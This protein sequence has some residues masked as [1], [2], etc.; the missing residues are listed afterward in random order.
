M[1]LR[2][3]IFGIQN[4]RCMMNYALL[5]LPFLT[6]FYLL[7]HTA[8]AQQ[9]EF[10][11]LLNDSYGDGWNGGVLT[12]TNGPTVLQLILSDG[13]DSIVSFSATSG[14][15]VQLNWTPGNIDFE[16]SISLLNNDGDLLFSVTDP[17]AGSL[18][19]IPA[20][21]IACLKPLNVV[22]E[23]VYD[24][25]AKVRWAPAVGT[26]LPVGWWVIYD[27]TGFTPGP[28]KGDSLYVMLPKATIPGLAKKTFYDFYVQQDC[29]NGETGD[30]TGPFTFETYRSDDVGITGAPSP[31]SGCDL[32]VE[33]V[34]IRMTNFGANPQS[35]I[36]FNYSVNG[37][38]AGVPQPQD[39][40][41]TGVIGKDSTTIIEFETQ[42]DF[43]DPGE[44]LIEVWTEMN[45]DE[46]TANDTFR[47]RI[48]NRLEAPYEQDFETWSGGWHVDTSAS[49]FS[50]WEFGTPNTPGIP[51]AASGKNAWVTNLDGPYSPGELSYL[52]SP[53]FD[54][55]NLANDPVIEFSLIYETETE[56]DGGFLEMSDDDG[57]NW[58]KIGAIEE[59][60]NWYNFDNVNTDLGLVWAG[61]SNGWVIA[62]HRLPGAAGKASVR[63][64]FGFGSDPLF[65]FDGMGVD[66]IRV[67]EPVADDLAGLTISTNADGEDCGLVDDEV[68][69]RFINLG[70]Q[71]QTL[72]SVSYALNGTA[73]VTENV[74]PV[75]VNPDEIFEYTFTT[76]FNSQ[77]GLFE[78]K[79]WTNLAGDG[80]PA[81]DTA[82]Y[83][84]DHLPDPVP[85]H[86]DFEAGFP[87]GWQSNG[88]VTSGHNNISQVLALRMNNNNP[89]FTAELPRVGFVSPGDTFTFDYRIVNFAGAGGV[90]TTLSGGTKFEVLIS[91][92]C[93]DNF[94]TAYTINAANHTPSV[95]LQTVAID[96]LPYIGLSVLI[97]FKGTWAAGDFYFD[98]DNINLRAC[99]ADMNL[100]AETV[101]AD[102]GQNNGS[103][104][105]N[106]GLGN[107]PYQYVW[108]T[109]DSTQTVT[110]LTTGTVTVT[111]TDDLGCSSV[112][113]VLIGNSPV[114]EIPGLTR[115]TL[116]PNPTTGATT[117]F[118][119]LDHPAEVQVQL[120]DLT[121]R[122]VWSSAPIQS[123]NLSERLDL[124]HYPDGM[125]LIR[126]T[127]DGR[128]VVRKLVKG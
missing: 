84:L 82:T 32:G 42:Y 50:S 26:S 48:V 12:L 63:L 76:P 102:P 105:V 118:V 89:S 75:V 86:E 33:T 83:V 87:A 125:Y 57:A 64:R 77:D 70:A 17:N 34:T 113:N 6:I 13:S 1:F 52:A 37:I 108:S 115:F 35:L 111:V 94:Q 16:V 93:G 9:C 90:A 19:N 61:S 124:S 41:Y 114:N 20:V 126:L 11:L 66:D 80:E 100:S 31:E 88:S 106:V 110:G 65:Q 74:G 127:A 40:F 36:P 99:P 79:S 68:T 116:Q 97:R 10:R 117:L 46:F 104:T 24:T 23:N 98:L 15:P 38:P 81:N 71:P 55:S 78:I 96:L 21:C 101:P 69:F 120:L 121:G 39:G 73:P 43:S 59:G 112:L 44:Y 103:A 122:L 25:Y 8:G 7:L 60:L 28:G 53:C 91:T 109:G 92:D 72:I 58:V 107:P 95:G 22:I 2:R 4:L 62:R 47:F 128:S 119:T 51:S 18:Y 45:G 85:V 5:R 49:P 54:F 14:T 29:G 56:Y 30:L 67:F 3:P 27:S 123:D